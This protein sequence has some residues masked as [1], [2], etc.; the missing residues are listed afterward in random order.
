MKDFRT[1]MDETAAYHTRMQDEYERQRQLEVVRKAVRDGLAS[2]KENDE[3]F[4][5]ALIS[6]TAED[7]G[8]RLVEKE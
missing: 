1:C 5:R 7:L 6:V 4:M 2:M 3:W 8:Y